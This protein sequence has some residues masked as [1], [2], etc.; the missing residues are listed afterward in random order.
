MDIWAVGC[1]FYEMLTLN[2]LFPGENELDQLNLIHK[3]LGSPS[4][5]VLAKFRHLNELKY[6]FP[7]R[8]PTGFRNLVQLL[9]QYGLDVL[10]RTLAYAPEARISAGKLLQH[11]YFEDMW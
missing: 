1:C 10:N 6:E 2:P 8:K 9:S 11:L 7:K 5:T 4:P 3:V